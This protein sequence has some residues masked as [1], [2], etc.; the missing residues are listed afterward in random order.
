METSKS[1]TL[2]Q[3]SATILQVT[4][5]EDIRSD[6]RIQHAEYGIFEALVI[7]TSTRG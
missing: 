7:K 6:P 4:R 1:I 2:L 3:S 5:F